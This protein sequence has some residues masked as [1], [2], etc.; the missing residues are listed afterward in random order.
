MATLAQIFTLETNGLVVLWYFNTR[1]EEKNL[2]TIKTVY[3]SLPTRTMTASASLG[4]LA[5]SFMD[6]AAAGWLSGGRGWRDFL[7]KQRSE[8]KKKEKRTS[9]LCQPMGCDSRIYLGTNNVHTAWKWQSIWAIIQQL[10]FLNC[11]AGWM[12]LF[13]EHDSF[14]GLFGISQDLKPSG[15]VCF[16]FFFKVIASRSF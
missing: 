7:E 13:V 2:Q 6:L 5:R 12:V 11:A 10:C 3:K 4:I 15:T 9:L 16:F 8:K 1:K 14:K